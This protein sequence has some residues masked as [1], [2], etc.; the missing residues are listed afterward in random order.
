MIKDSLIEHDQQKER[1]TYVI[2]EATVTSANDFFRKLG[3]FLIIGD[4]ADSPRLDFKPFDWGDKKE[5]DASSD[6]SNHLAAELV[7][8]GVNFGRSGYTLYDTHSSRSIL[9]FQDS[10]IGKISG[11]TDAVIAPFKCTREFCSQ[12]LCVA[13]EFKTPDADYTTHI[14][15]AMMELIAARC[16]SEQPEV[17]VVL[18]DLSYGAICYRFT[19]NEDDVE[20]ASSSCSSA[21]LSTTAFVAIKYTTT[22]SQM[23]ELVADFLSTR[24]VPNPL[25]R[26]IEP[27]GSNRGVIEFK[28]QK[29]SHDEMLAWE[30]FQEF[31]DS[32]QPW[33]WERAKLTRDLFSELHC[34]MPGLTHPSMYI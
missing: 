16:L 4:I 8:F 25:F 33:S 14:P 10:K 6:A 13:F 17:L 28:K 7:K 15:Q 30:H 24:A 31:K 27:E 1:N 18:T 32:T 3:V 21:G 20:T 12:Q 19:F 11:G 9:S 26:A 34:P 5:T 22:L 29:L 23:G 2:S